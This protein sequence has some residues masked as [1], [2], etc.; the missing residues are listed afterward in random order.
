MDLAQERTFLTSRRRPNLEDTSNRSN[1]GLVTT[2]LFS[3]SALQA[4]G[5]DVFPL[6]GLLG[7]TA[8][9]NMVY[10]NTNT[11]SSGVVCGV[12]GSG[13][14]HTVSC[15]LENALV[16]D[17]R[18]GNLPQPLAG[19][20]FHFDEEDGDRPCEAAYLGTPIAG[21]TNN[22]HV[23]HIT[24][25]ASSVNLA[26]RRRAYANL[27]NVDVQPLLL[28]EADITAPR[29]LTLMG[30]S[31]DAA[32]HLPLYMHTILQI[33]RE[34]GPEGFSYT[35][36]KHRIAH[37][38]F[39]GT[40]L[41]MLRHR[42]RL[43]DGFVQSE[44]RPIRSYFQAG[45][46]VLVDLTD[47]FLN[48]LLA[49]LL[50]D[51]VLSSFMG[52][53]SP[54]GRIVVLDEAHKYLTNSE[55]SRLN[56]SIAT[57]IRQQRHLAT[58]VIIATQE[59][60][61]VPATVLDLSSFIVCHRF[62]SPSWCSHLS[63]HVSTGNNVWFQDVMNLATGDAI[64]FSPTARVTEALTPL[65]TEAMYISIRPRLTSDGGA[66]V[67]AVGSVTQEPDLEDMRDELGIAYTMVPRSPSLVSIDSMASPVLRASSPSLS[68]SLPSVSNPNA[69]HLPLLSDRPASATSS[70]LVH[71]GLDSDSTAVPM[72]GA[73]VIEGI[74]VTVPSTVVNSVAGTLEAESSSTS[75]HTVDA[76]TLPAYVPAPTAS[77]SGTMLPLAPLDQYQA[78]V[79]LNSSVTLSLAPHVS[80]IVISTTCTLLAELHR[81]ATVDGD[82]LYL[83]L[84][85]I[86]R[87]LHGA[88]RAGI[89]CDEMVFR[90][91]AQV[92]ERMGLVTCFTDG[93]GQMFVRLMPLVR[94]MNTSSSAPVFVSSSTSTMA[95]PE[96]SSSS[97][98]ALIVPWLVAPTTTPS[99]ATVSAI[100]PTTIVAGTATTPLSSYLALVRPLQ[101][102]NY[103]H[104]NL[105][106]VR[107]LAMYLHSQWV[108]TGFRREYGLPDL[109]QHVH[110]LTGKLS[111]N[112]E[113]AEAM[114]ILTLK[115]KKKHVIAVQLTQ[116]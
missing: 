55:S 38:R 73:T 14:S 30:W 35:E 20:V 10:F 61:V 13:K 39:N 53:N 12:Q 22:A 62:S 104:D 67:L 94:R 52:W 99:A 113:A 97:T 50:F 18:I 71:V 68:Y 29:L 90:Q 19:L 26:N 48:G 103:T 100:A 11:P 60:T 95:V 58:R 105:P 44:A 75:I 15:L 89:E 56:R 40:Q 49:S 81:L 114:G 5:E 24:V 66:S 47:P 45:E 79:G 77:R 6:R 32:E 4:A 110:H 1:H 111:A 59:P 34:I 2:P 8:E 65:G 83:R 86:W 41:M 78:Q 9:D 21:T 69:L 36:F 28:G 74:E 27:Q 76:H 23:R 102:Y 112:C 116:L 98:K 84:D 3:E 46:M 88:N 85:V 17:P 54:T 72:Y 16:M 64:V 43:L 96:A 107:A 63:R 115:R 33:V 87:G 70:S 7:V 93:Q 92:A 106:S 42:L 25:L 31:D 82:R 37:E 91:A 57:I 51:I 101:Q 80:A 109:G 108:Q